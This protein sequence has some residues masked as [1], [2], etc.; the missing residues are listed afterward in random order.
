M[1]GRTWEVKGGFCLEWQKFA[2]V[3][4]QREGAHREGK[5]EDMERR[6]S[7]LGQGLRGK[8]RELNP[9]TKEGLPQF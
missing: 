2:H 8:Q 9:A 4:N 7:L 3:Y 1:P 6:R 5:A